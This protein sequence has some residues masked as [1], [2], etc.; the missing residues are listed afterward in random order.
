MEIMEKKMEATTF[1]HKAPTPA[2]TGGDRE[3]LPMSPA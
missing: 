3:G 2:P 1:S